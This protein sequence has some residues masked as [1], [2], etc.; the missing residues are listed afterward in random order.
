MK[1]TLANLTPKDAAEKTTE[2]VFILDRSGSMAGLEKDTIGGFNSMIAKQR[3]LPG[4]GFVTTVLFDHRV[5]TLTEREPLESVR[6][7]TADQYYVRGCTA[8][9][10]AVGETIRR[11]NK[12][13][14]A[15]V[16][17]RPDH[18]VFVIATDGME[19]ASKHYTLEDVRHAIEKRQRKN[20][21][22]F[23]FLGAN[24]DAVATA[25]SMGIDSRRAA[26]YAATPAGTEVMY[27]AVDAALCALRL[28]GVLGEDWKDGL[29]G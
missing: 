19:N 4:R 8:L 5:E 11:V 13:Q 28:D 29:A 26:D 3:H 7:L 23:V 15:N 1:K 22:E 2:L 14:K 20:S 16:A 17:G 10:D 25:G 9:L 27:G 24:I 6:D 21:W 18:T 12:A